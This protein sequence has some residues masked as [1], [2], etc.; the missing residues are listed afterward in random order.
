MVHEITSGA[1]FNTYLEQSEDKLL[2]I[3]FFATWCPPCKAITPFFAQLSETHGAKA[4]FIKV[5]VDQH[6][7]LAQAFGVRAMPTFVFIKNKK[8]I[9]DVRGAN[10]KA[11][12]ATLVQNL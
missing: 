4:N 12:E 6:G 3:D 10:P 11:I 5:D 7:Q 9:A 1:D 2:V 8:K